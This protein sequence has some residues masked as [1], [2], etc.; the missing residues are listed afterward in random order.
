MAI[1][2]VVKQCTG[3]RYYNGESGVIKM[4]KSVR[5]GLISGLALAMVLFQMNPYVAL[6]KSKVDSSSQYHV[7]MDNDFATCGVTVECRLQED[8]RRKN[9]VTQYY[10]RHGYIEYRKVGNASVKVEVTRPRHIN[11]SS[12]TIKTFSDWKSSPYIT[13]LGAHVVFSGENSTVVSYGNNYSNKSIIAYTVGNSDLIGGYQ[14]G[15]ATVKL[16]VC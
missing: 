1:T 2:Y 16:N 3:S 9:G 15:N 12:K 8:Y 13:S 4:R 10:S 14:S 6:A 11:A 5:R 7:F